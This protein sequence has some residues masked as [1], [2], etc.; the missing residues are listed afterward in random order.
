MRFPDLDR[1][2]L[3]C[4]F[5]GIVPGKLHADGRR[6]L[7]LLLLR[8][9]AESEADGLLL[10]VVDRHHRV[11]PALEGQYG[12]A[13]LVCALS[14]LRLQEGAGSYGLVGESEVEQGR[15]SLSPLIRGRVAEVYT[16]ERQH[17]QLPYETLYTE[18]LV[19]V[20]VG[21]LGVRTSFTAADLAG[22]PG[23]TSLAVGDWI[24]MARSRIDILGFLPEG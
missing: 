5:E 7:P 10:G 21:T 11:D 2:R 8:L 19:D 22:V 18:L 9:P 4:L 17:E 20:G 24:E 3:P 1:L 23:K 14:V 13:R 6:Y 12:S 16:W 15:A